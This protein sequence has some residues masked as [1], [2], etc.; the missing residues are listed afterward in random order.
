[1]SISNPIDAYSTY[2]NNE[3]GRHEERIILKTTEKQKVI[4][5]PQ[6]NQ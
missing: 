4:A 5:Q 2:D 3:H 6:K 1:M